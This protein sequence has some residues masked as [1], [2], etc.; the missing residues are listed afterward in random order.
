MAI[1]EIESGGH[2]NEVSEY[3]QA[4]VRDNNG[5]RCTFVACSN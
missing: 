2:M 5:K 4:I 1:D 3:R